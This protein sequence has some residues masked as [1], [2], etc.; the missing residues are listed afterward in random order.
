MLLFSPPAEKA[1]IQSF[2]RPSSVDCKS[3]NSKC[4]HS[5]A[6][7]PLTANWEISNA[8]IQPP[9]FLWPQ[10]KKFKMQ[11]LDRLSSVD[12][13]SKNAKCSHSTAL[14]PL[15]ANQ[16]I[17]NAV[18]RLPFF[19]WPQI[20]KSQMQSKDSFLLKKNWIYSWLRIEWREASLVNR[21]FE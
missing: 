7:L 6:L 9:C 10:I 11:S 12:R 20:K 13:K 3:K 19:C 21:E 8:V 1:Q 18:T 16:K 15:T 5:T 17:P 4:G 14:L 2:D